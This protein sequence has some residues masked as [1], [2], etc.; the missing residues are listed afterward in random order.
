MNIQNPVPFYNFE[1]T[2]PDQT[3]Q[4]NEYYFVMASNGEYLKSK[5]LQEFE[6]IKSWR[7]ILFSGKVK[8]NQYVYFKIG[9]TWHKKNFSQLSVSNSCIFGVFDLHL[10][11][12]DFS[13]LIFKIRIGG[14]QKPESY[15][16]L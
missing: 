8:T 1:T 13:S 12:T 9:S 15:E 5:N 11:H 4:L 3:L 6:E 14:K 2:K 7:N 16:L 10:I